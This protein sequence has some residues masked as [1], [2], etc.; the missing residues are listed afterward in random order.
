M[1]K[2]QILNEINLKFKVLKALS[3]E[4]VNYKPHLYCI[5]EEHLNLNTSIYLGEAE[6]KEIEFKEGKGLCGMYVKG[7]KF[8]NTYKT[9]YTKCH[10]RYEEHTCDTVCF[11]ELKENCTQSQILENFKSVLDILNENKIDGVVIIKN[12]FEIEQV[13]EETK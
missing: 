3:I 4:N 13:K 12:Q 8:T 7:D 11:V 6:I 1:E 2:E 10:L 9:G 5:S